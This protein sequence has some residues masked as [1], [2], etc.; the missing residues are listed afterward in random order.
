MNGYEDVRLGTT[1]YQ[2]RNYEMARRCYERAA[3]QNNSAALYNL[4]NFYE[5]GLGVEQNYER[6]AGY[7]EI[8]ANLGNSNAVNMLGWFYQNGFG[9]EQD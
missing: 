4:G 3:E 8:A 1:Y 6:A 9:V 7:Y 5:L 2:Q